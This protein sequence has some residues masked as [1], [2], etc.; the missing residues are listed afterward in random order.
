MDKLTNRRAYWQGKGVMR[1]RLILDNVGHGYSRGFLFRNVTLELQP[2][3]AAVIA[4]PNGVGKTT[5]LRI[6][7]GLLTPREGKV[8]YHTDTDALP[9]VAVRPRLG[10]ITPDIS[11]YSELTARENVLLAG[12]LRGVRKT[13]DVGSS[14]GRVGLAGREEDLV[15]SFSLGMRQRLKYACL[16]AYQPEVLLLDEPCSNLDEEGRRM[17]A[18]L[19][20]RH[21]E[22][23]VVVIATNDPREVRWGEVFIHLG[24]DG[25]P[26]KRC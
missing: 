2:G 17:V 5:L 24:S 16:F 20:L 1:T 14:L 11:L 12:A 21:R 10:L 8:V 4:G 25:H 6:L 19:V 15:G 18:D 26:A 13:V 22:G 9:S 7:A 3:S 23:G